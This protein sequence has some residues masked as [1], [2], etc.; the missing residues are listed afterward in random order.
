M[1]QYQPPPPA[2]NLTPCLHHPLNLISAI[3]TQ[4]PIIAYHTWNSKSDSRQAGINHILAAPEHMHP[5]SISGIDHD[6]SVSLFKSDHYLI[7]DSFN[8]HWLNTAPTPPATTQFQYRR[9]AQIPL[10]KTY[11]KDDND[12]TPPWFASKTIDILLDGVSFHTK[13]HDAIAC[14][15]LDCTFLV[16]GDV[17]FISILFIIP[18]RNM[19]M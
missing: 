15:L 16:N 12:P 17:G 3:P 7:F 6:V 11:P 13:I 19:S 4:Q 2:K 14:G 1:G 18:S 8:L 9:V 10:R 5:T